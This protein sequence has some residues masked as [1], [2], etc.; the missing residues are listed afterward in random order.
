MERRRAVR[1]APPPERSLALRT[2]G[3][4]GLLRRNLLVEWID[5]SE[6]GLHAVVACELERGMRLLA[7]IE[8]LPERESFPVE[9]EV[10]RVRPS[11]A[12]PG[13]WEIGARFLAP[14]QVFRASIR[15]AE[16][17]RILR[18]LRLA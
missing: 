5:L 12:H 17:R 6:G 10:C 15:G 2:P 13:A 4:R 11:G 16:C 9:I 8:C 18:G 1:F 14:S 7:Q 3:W